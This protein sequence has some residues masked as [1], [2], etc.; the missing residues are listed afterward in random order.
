[1]PGKTNILSIA[2]SLLSLAFGASCFGADLAAFAN[3]HVVV[4]CAFSHLP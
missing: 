4:L 2:I 1:M 3:D